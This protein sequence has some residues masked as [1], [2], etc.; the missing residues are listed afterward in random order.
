M[1]NQPTAVFDFDGTIVSKDTGYHFYKW[2][3][4]QS[5]VRTT[6]LMVSLPV[7]V[8]LLFNSR[9]RR[10]GV[11]IACLIATILQSKALFRQRSAFI[12]HYFNAAGAV[13]Y[14]DALDAI[15]KHQ[16]RGEKILII[17]GCPD[18]LLS[19]VL[20]KIGIKKA[21]LIGSKLRM[22]WG[23]LLLKSHCYSNN[24]LRMAHERGQQTSSWIVGYSDSPV[25]IPM[26]NQCK[27]AVIINA[28][29]SRHN[30]FLKDLRVPSETRHW[31]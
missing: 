26:L 14:A 21:T 20:K 12:N 23:I 1:D 15:V 17:S 16:N 19:G 10:Y 2:L 9:T 29:P 27:R 28:S 18:W 6:L 3:I 5:V 11:N 8:P 7:L 24:K 25:D 13:V 4:G 31:K 30:V 22:D